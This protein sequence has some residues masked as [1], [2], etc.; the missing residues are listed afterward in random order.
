MLYDYW[1][2]IHK[3]SIFR[4]TNAHV[5]LLLLLLIKSNVILIRV[6]YATI[7]LP[8]I[9]LGQIGVLALDKIR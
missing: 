1:L 5:K 7:T 8:R 4:A 6:S 2:I 9:M 3:L